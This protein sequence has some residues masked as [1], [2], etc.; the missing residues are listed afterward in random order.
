MMPP[1]GALISV[2]AS[3]AAASSASAC[4]TLKVFSA[5]SLAWLEMKPLAR[6]SSARSYLE[7]DSVRLARARSRSAFWTESSRRMSTSGRASTRWPSW[8][9]ISATRP[10]I[11]GRTI[12]A[13]SERRLPT[14]VMEL[15]SLS[16]NG[17]PGFHGDAGRLAAAGA[18][19]GRGGGRR[20]RGGSGPAT[21][22]GE[23]GKR[24]DSRKQDNGADDRNG[25][26]GCR[27]ENGDY[28]AFAGL[29]PAFARCG[30]SGE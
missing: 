17:R 15:G 16:E 7:R 29:S 20:R 4:A 1:K 3:R 6:R 5:S 26:H 22:A 8:K 19:L 18:L 28:P 27:P 24:P 25:L 12:T 30:R 21:R 13:S 11:S 14:V 2:L 23:V 9:A 10:A